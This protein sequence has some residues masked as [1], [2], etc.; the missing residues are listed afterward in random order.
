MHIAITLR[1][2]QAE[3]VKRSDRIEPGIFLEALGGRGKTFCALAI[4]KH[5]CA[6]KI[7]ILNNRLSILKGWEESVEAFGFDD[8]VTF[9][10]QT[11]RKLQNMLKKGSSLD[12]D[13]LI[14]DE[15]Q[16]MSS[17]KQTALYRKIERKY[18][19]GCYTDS[20]KRSKLLSARK[21]YLRICRT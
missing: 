1:K 3:A 13:L 18:T 10:I 9:I 16:N 17:D 21:N 15:W 11:D 14:I 12:C 19:I 8:D 7:V 6:K 20:K 2:W 4:A 5:K